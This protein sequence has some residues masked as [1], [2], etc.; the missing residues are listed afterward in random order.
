VAERRK[1]TPR[2]SEDRM[3][4]DGLEVIDPEQ[5]RD[6][7]GNGEASFRKMASVRRS[8]WRRIPV[9]RSWGERASVW[10]LGKEWVFWTE[11]KPVLRDRWWL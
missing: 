8:R 3:E 5:R 6:A 7:K 10:E 1:G 11:A 4:R 9:M 2:R